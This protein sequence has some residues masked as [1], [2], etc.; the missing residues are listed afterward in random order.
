MTTRARVALIRTSPATVLHDYARLLELAEAH[1]HLDRS[2][3]TVLD[4]HVSQ[5]LPF[6]SANTTPW[7]LEGAAQWLRAAGYDDL[8]WV[9]P[10]DARGA[11]RHGEDLSGYQPI[12]RAY[13]IPARDRS[14]FA[15]PCWVYHK[16]QVPLLAPDQFGDAVRLPE[17]FL[18]KNVVHLPTLKTSADTLIAGAASNAAGR[19]RLRRHLDPALRHQVLVD[20]LAIQRE[21]AAGVFALIDGTTAGNG[22]WPHALAPEVKHVIL[23]SADQVAIDAVAAKLMGFDPLRD[24]PYIRLAHERGLGVG[25]VRQIALVGDADLAGQNWHFK[26]ALDTR[27]APLWSIQRLLARTPLRGALDFCLERYRDDYRWPARDRQIFES[28]L[29]CTGWG[30]LFQRYQ[31]GYLERR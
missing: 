5:H 26:L 21:T 28:W 30:Q 14:S 17:F 23:A 22:P 29:R 27:L 16:P 10:T 1:R 13:G 6:P 12:L 7:Q 4:A 31:Q 18:G 15:E 9:Q 20:A 19:V 3:A 8:V 2:A 25:D 11:A 24:V